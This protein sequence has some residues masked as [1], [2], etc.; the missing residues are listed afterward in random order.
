MTDIITHHHQEINNEINN[1]INNLLTTMFNKIGIDYS[2]SELDE[3][4]KN[5]KNEKNEKNDG[6]NVKFSFPLMSEKYEKYNEKKKKFVIPLNVLLGINN[7]NYKEHAQYD[8]ELEE[9]CQYGLYCPHKN[10]PIKCPLNHHSMNKVIKKY[11]IIPNLFCRY[12]REWKIMNDKPMRCLNPNC[13]YNHGKGR[14]NIIRNK[15]YY[16]YT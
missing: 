9:M 4:D 1:D 14:A 15:D 10:D 12:E 16:K 8:I 7:N 5:D 6:I 13:W 2:C 3:I 11:E